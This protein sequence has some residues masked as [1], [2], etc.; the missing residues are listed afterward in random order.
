[1][2]RSMRL[3][4]I[5]HGETV[6]NVA[7]LYAGS[8]D[9]ALT[10]HGYQQATRLGLHF[11]S[12]DLTFTH[13]FSSH[14]QRAVKT[15]GRIRDAQLASTDDDNTAKAVP[16]VKQLPVLMEKD[17]GSMEGKK[18]HDR[19]ENKD[20]T[21]FADAESKDSMARRADSF[22]NEHLLPL[23]DEASKDADLVVAI[24]SHGIFL[25]TLWK[26]LLLHLPHKSVAL[27]PGLQAIARP[28]LEHLGGWSNTG[29]L[30]L[31]MTRIDRGD[32]TVIAQVPA[33]P[34]LERCS[35]L[36][37][38]PATNE[39]L[40]ETEAS[41]PATEHGSAPQQVSQVPTRAAVAASP[42]I[43]PRIARGWSSTI[44]AINGKDH[45][46]GIKRTR[47]GIGSSRH[48]ASQSSIKI[49]FKRCKT[50]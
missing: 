17:F 4:L 31:R 46:R 21:S 2:A 3:F 22:L 38:M 7:Q 29:Y 40:D 9:S 15:A 35:S 43:R 12:L 13:I 5:R 30:E 27:S 39:G 24:V 32:S 33:V 42:A 14:L 44:L 6:D 20:T 19:P 41:D 10:N 34:T 25:S 18:F 47:G 36:V 49:F 16:D 48:D 28:S 45:L 1:M 26:R 50:V 8:R 37:E 11:K 23:L